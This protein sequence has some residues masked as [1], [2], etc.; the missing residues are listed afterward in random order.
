MTKIMFLSPRQIS[1]NFLENI[2]TLHIA[3]ICFLTA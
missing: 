2:K 1:S 3:I